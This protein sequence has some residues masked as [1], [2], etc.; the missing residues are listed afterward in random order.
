LPG[1]P[2]GPPVHSSRDLWTPSIGVQVNVWPGITARGNLGRFERAPSFSELFGSRGAVVGNS[3]LQ[4]ETGI[5]RDAGVVAT[6][7]PW[8]LL[9]SIRAE[10]AYFNNDIDDLIVLVQ[11]SPSVSIPMNVS[12][13][14]VRGHELTLGTAVFEHL[15]L[16]TNY[17]HYDAVNQSN[18][19]L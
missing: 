12:A 8:S 10:Y 13:A 1:N 14:R 19:F 5:N 4:P 11:N 15:R 6:V 18:T 7:G 3:K 2:L 17:T 9:D 16:D